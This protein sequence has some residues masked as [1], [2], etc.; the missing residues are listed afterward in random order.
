MA[1]LEPPPTNGTV[2]F[3]N[4]FYME[5]DTVGVSVIDANAVLPM[6]VTLESSSGDVETL[7]LSPGVILHEYTGTIDTAQ[8]PNAADGILQVLLGDVITVTYDDPDDGT[9][10]PSQSQDTATISDITQYNSNDTPVNIVD[11]TTVTSVISVADFGT[12]NDIDVELDITHTWDGDLDVFLTS[13]GGTTVELFSG[14]GGSGDNFIDTL[15]N[16]EAADSITTG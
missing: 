5:V 8:G 14:V 10:A 16:D 9:G 12:V 1:I 3:D 4:G 7:T 15:L 13:P 11:N 2:S 6:T